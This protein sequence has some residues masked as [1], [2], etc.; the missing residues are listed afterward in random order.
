MS[1]LGSKISETARSESEVDTW[2]IAVAD[3]LCAYVERL[4]TS[5]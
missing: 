4:D 3:M 1:A 2:A 5:G